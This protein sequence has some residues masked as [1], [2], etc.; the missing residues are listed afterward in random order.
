ME[1]SGPAREGGSGEAGLGEG[2]KGG[3]RRDEKHT[4]VELCAWHHIKSITRVNSWSIEKT[5]LQHLCRSGPVS[6]ISVRHQRY[7]KLGGI[8]VAKPKISFR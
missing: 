4:F 5:H 3:L 8:L 6:Q 2:E 7:L 1:G